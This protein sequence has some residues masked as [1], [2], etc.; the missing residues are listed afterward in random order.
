MKS[1]VRRLAAL[2]TVGVVAIVAPAAS[3][4]AATTPVTPAA[5]GLPFSGWGGAGLGLGDLGG[6]TPAPIP[7]APIGGA[8][9]V[10]PIIITTAPSSFINTNN[11]V[12]AGSNV[13]GGQVAP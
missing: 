1:N 7:F 10:G 11:Q 4:S 3:A 8:V 13:A 5:F 12:S 6:F 9:V 2:A